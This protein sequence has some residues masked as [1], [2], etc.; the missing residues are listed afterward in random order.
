MPEADRF[1]QMDRV[2]QLAAGFQV[3]PTRA[4]CS[5]LLDRVLQHLAPD[6][7]PP[8]TLGNRHLGKFELTRLHGKQCTAADWL[9]IGDGNKNVSAWLQDLAHRIA[10]CDMVLLFHIEMLGDPLFIE[11]AEGLFVA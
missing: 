3:Q 4:Q 5:G 2:G 1:I 7:V 9:A 10:Q 8:V 11:L 6:T